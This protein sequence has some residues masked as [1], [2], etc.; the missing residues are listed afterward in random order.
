[1][2]LVSP[3]WK[4]LPRTTSPV[5]RI[6]RILN[7]PVVVSPAARPDENTKPSMSAPLPLLPSG[8]PLTM[9]MGSGDPV[10]AVAPPTLLSG[11]LGRNVVVAAP[12]AAPVARPAPSS[13]MFIAPR[14]VMP[15][16]STTSGKC[17]MV[18]SADGDV[19][20]FSTPAA[21]VM[22][23]RHAPL[24]SSWRAMRPARATASASVTRWK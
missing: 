20:P 17:S 4:R 9:K 19:V 8:C 6:A 23:M 21:T 22:V 7:P 3:S 18:E 12:S 14:S 11:G 5:T 24:S 16:T 2:A 15:G 13:G 10:C 1:M